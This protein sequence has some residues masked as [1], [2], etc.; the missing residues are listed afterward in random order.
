MTKPPAR[1]QA[2]DSASLTASKG[3]PSSRIAPKLRHAIKL[4]VE[5]GLTITEACSRAGISEAGWHKAFKRPAVIAAFEQTETAFI[6]TVDRRR[7][8]YKARAFE[9]AADLM[10]RGTTE[11]VRMRAV[12]F[13][14]G[15]GKPGTQVNVAVNVDRGGYEFVKP[16]QRVVDIRPSLDGAS[17][18]D[19]AQAIDDADITPDAAE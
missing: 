19:G 2:S 6:A 10:E 4:R 18:D 12:E 16:G 8:G 13:F 15:E 5:Q 9:V 14:A 1:K 7:A 3:S 17:S 11:A